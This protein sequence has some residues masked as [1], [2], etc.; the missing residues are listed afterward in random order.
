MWTLTFMVEGEKRVERVPDDWVE[1]VRKRVQAGR[2]FH[3]A[4]KEVFTANA[5]LLALWR[6]RQRR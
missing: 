2:R 1:E 4:V 6:K 3:E 5:L